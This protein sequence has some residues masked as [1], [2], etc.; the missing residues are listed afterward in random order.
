M[1]SVVNHGLWVVQHF[2]EPNECF[3]GYPLTDAT[4][5]GRYR[6][7]LSYAIYVVNAVKV[8]PDTEFGSVQCTFT[9]SVVGTVILDYLYFI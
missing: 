7:G 5:V 2:S 4:T 6:A 9:L 1:K 3:S 8:N